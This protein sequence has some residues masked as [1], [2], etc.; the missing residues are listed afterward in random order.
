MNEN[1]W[2]SCTTIII[3]CIF[4]FGF[5]VFTLFAPIKEFSETENRVLAE[6][7]KL[8][9]KEILN[10]E[11]EKN[12]EEYLTDQFILRDSWIGLKTNVEKLLLKMESKDI[13]FADDDYLIE[14]HTGVFETDIANRNAR[15]LSKFVNQ[16][17]NQFGPNHISI[18]IVPNAVDILTDKL[19]PF[20][21][22]YNQE[23]YLEELKRTIPKEVWID[24]SK[25]LKKHKEEEIYYRTD[26]HWKTLASFYAYQEWAKIK[27]FNI[28]KLS[29]YE[30]KTVADDF[31]GTI[32][33]KLGIET[34]KDTIELFLPKTDIPYTIQY[35]NK[36][37]IQNNLY[38]YS[39][40]DTKDK[41]AIYFGGNEPFIKINTELD[42]ERKILV[43]KDSYA[44]SFIPFMI[45]EF[46]SIDIVDLRY[47]S[48]KLSEIITKGNYTD[49]LVLYNASL[50]A[51]DISITKL[52][53]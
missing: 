52:T 44:N 16:Y 47:T 53:N 10:G 26:H 27:G 22:P 9:L 36:G 34:K 7:P 45:G 38:N 17:Q 13:Y 42:N 35:G 23:K 11:Y 19:P 21:T 30:I 4:I 43:I 18:M 29:D 24:T 39:A 51:E 3:F 8:E 20:A 50:F 33:S 12:Y 37:T 2:Q 5:S 28:P 40:L 32:Q 41:Y 49:L 46:E 6:K 1:K 25:I 31:E 14:K 48:E 15:L